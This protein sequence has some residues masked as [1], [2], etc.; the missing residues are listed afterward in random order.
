MGF[1]VCF[2]L[3]WSVCVRI[4]ALYFYDCYCICYTFWIFLHFYINFM[5]LMFLQNILCFLLA[6]K[7]ILKINKVLNSANVKKRTF[8]CIFI[9]I[10]QNKSRASLPYLGIQFLPFSLLFL[11]HI[12]PPSHLPIIFFLFPLHFTFILQGVLLL[13]FNWFSWVF[14]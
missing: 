1:C 5:Y 9:Y 4:Y 2:N 13:G 11:F 3:C 7:Q 6:F 10:N 14:F 8:V 12:S